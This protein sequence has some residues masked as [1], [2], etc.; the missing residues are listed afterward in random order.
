MIS[1]INYQDIDLD[2]IKYN[3]LVSFKKKNLLTAKYNNE[4]L[5]TVIKSQ[6]IFNIDISEKIILIELEIDNCFRNFILDIDAFN[7][8][9]I[10]SNHKKWFKNKYNLDILENKYKTNLCLKKNTPKTILQFKIL[11]D[12]PEI[13]FQIYD[14]HKNKISIF[15]IKENDEIHLLL[16]Y[17]GLIID[18]KNTKFEAGWNIFQIRVIKNIDEKKNSIKFDNCKIFDKYDSDDD[19][20]IENTTYIKYI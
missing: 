20:I 16:Q 14:K 1:L 13:P 15:D 12:V 5:H 10:D 2:L 19:N 18:N 8:N 4:P 3:T 17:S 11:L 6:R 7:K 9:Y